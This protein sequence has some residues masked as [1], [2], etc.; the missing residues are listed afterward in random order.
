M[1]PDS[2]NPRYSYGGSKIATELITFDYARTHYRSVQVFRPHNVYGPNMGRK[3]VIPQF[4]LRAAA[5]RD[6]AHSPT[7]P[8]PIQGDGSQTRAF[9]FVEDII[10]GILAMYAHGAHREVYHI[11]ND[12]EVSI[13]DLALRVAKEIGVELYIQPGDAPEGGTLRR[14]PNITKCER[15]VINRRWVSTKACGEPSA[16]T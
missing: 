14:C 13:R 6:A 11:G 8:F 9:C 5:G 4:M 3:H 15:W 7:V 12:E 10:N 16:G 2:L 1:L